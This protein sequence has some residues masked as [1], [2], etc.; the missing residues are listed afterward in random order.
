MYG[1]PA[2]FAAVVI[3]FQML[4]VKDSDLLLGD[5]DIAGVFCALVRA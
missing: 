1:L 2:L 5:I 4:L 3:V